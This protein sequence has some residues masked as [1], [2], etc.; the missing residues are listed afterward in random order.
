MRRHQFAHFGL[1]FSRGSK[2]IIS[3]TLLRLMLLPQ[4]RQ[5]AH[6]R[7][8]LPAQRFFCIT[9]PVMHVV[10]DKGRHL[11]PPRGIQ[12]HM[13][14]PSV[15]LVIDI[16]P[17]QAN[18]PPRKTGQIL[19]ALDQQ[20][21]PLVICKC[22]LAAGHRTANGQTAY[23]RLLIDIAYQAENFSVDLLRKGDRSSS[24][25]PI[26]APYS[27]SMACF[28]CSSLSSQMIAEGP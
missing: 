19:G 4:R 18:E 28:A 23:I 21:Q 3:R 20:G 1:Y 17:C 9:H 22:D 12:R 24:S 15:F 14:T 25:F 7:E 11:R 5:R 6:A 2:V 26:R 13:R 16:Q 27:P 10:G 8:H